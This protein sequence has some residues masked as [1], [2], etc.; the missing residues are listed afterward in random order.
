LGLGEGNSSFRGILNAKDNYMKKN[1]LLTYE[2]RYEKIEEKTF[3]TSETSDNNTKKLVL[4]KAI[5]H[6]PQTSNIEPLDSD[7]TASEPTVTPVD[8]PTSPPSTTP[9]PTEISTDIVTSI[10][11]KTATPVATHPEGFE[12][13]RV[14]TYKDL[15][16]KDSI[17]N[18][19]YNSKTV[20]EIKDIS[21]PTDL[22][23]YV[24]EDS[25]G[26]TISDSQ[27]EA[28]TSWMEW[29]DEL[30]DNFYVELFV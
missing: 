5:D 12:I 15:G 22:Q 19:L 14:I 27:E 1:N 17:G 25:L 16:A 23:K 7:L 29:I 13:I 8:P 24:L 28:I 3:Q 2:G 6:I 18:V 4:M 30:I 26:D 20:Y 11:Q 9:Y 21:N 10:P